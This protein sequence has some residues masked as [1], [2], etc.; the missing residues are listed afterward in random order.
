MRK[1]LSLFAFLALFASCIT[2]NSDTLSGTA[3]EAAVNPLVVPV[4]EALSGM[5]AFMDE[6]YGPETRSGGRRAVSVETVRASDLGISTRADD[7]MDVDERAYVVNFG[8][9]EGFALLGANIYMPSIICITEAGSL[10]ME[11]LLAEPEPE[12]ET[13]A[14]SGQLKWM[15]YQDIHNFNYASGT[16]NPAPYLY[17]DYCM[18]WDA[19]DVKTE[20]TGDYLIY[21]QTDLFVKKSLHQYI[22][23]ELDPVPPTPTVTVVY[24]AWT[25]PKSGKIG[26]LLNTQWNQGSPFNTYTPIKGSDHAPAGCVSI[27]LAQIIACIGQPAPSTFNRYGAVTSTWAE[28][29]NYDYTLTSTDVDYNKRI[30]NDAAR[31]V[32]HVGHNVSMDYGAGGSAAANGAA[33][34]Y[35]KDLGYSNVHKKKGYKAD[36]INDMLSK[37]RPVYIAATRSGGHAHAWVIDGSATLTRTKRTF[38]NGVLS[39]TSTQSQFMLH[40]NYGWAG[41]ADGYYIAK[42]FDPSV[43]ALAT[44]DGNSSGTSSTGHYN[45]AYRIIKYTR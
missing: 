28:L 10:T 27:A 22:V 4:D 16:V 24:G 23:K 31:I 7:P 1:L 3:D 34:K 26:P 44:E 29:R 12:S 5:Y 36:V 11:E 14:V 18:D 2:D 33:K 38:I 41:N 13:R 43:G 39:N 9:D 35:L 45:D 32:R 37:S 6:V 40:C 19:D 25:V 17:N 20:D 30:E 42:M 15:S 21:A 8:D